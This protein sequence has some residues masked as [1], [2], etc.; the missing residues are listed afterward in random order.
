VA[1]AGCVE[2]LLLAQAL[3]PT[4][5]TAT[6]MI[7]MIFMKFPPFICWLQAAT[8]HPAAENINADF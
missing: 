1:G 6:R 2:L 8:S 7:D 3:K 5:A 4:S